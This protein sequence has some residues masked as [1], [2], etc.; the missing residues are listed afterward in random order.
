MS[1]LLT[2][3]CQYAIRAIMFLATQ[4]ENI[5]VLQR[6]I[7]EILNIPNHF[8][9]KILQQLAKHDIVHSQRGKS[10]GFTL[11]HHAEELTLYKIAEIVDGEK[12]LDGC[13]VGFPNCSDVNPCPVH[14]EW[15]Q[16]KEMIIAFLQRKQIH[17]LSGKL[18]PK[19]EDLSNPGEHDA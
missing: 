1:L 9:G 10:G 19:L 18:E 14:K 2:K 12:F 7:A 4:P 6:D 11:C 3:S 8:L 15:K 17:Q 16:M 5:P 13:V